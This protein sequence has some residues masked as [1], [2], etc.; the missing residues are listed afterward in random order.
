[1]SFK[2]TFE[3][4]SFLTHWI[5]ANKLLLPLMMLYVEI[6]LCLAGKALVTAS[7]RTLE[8]LVFN[9]RQHMIFEM[10]LCEERLPATILGASMHPVSLRLKTESSIWS[11][12]LT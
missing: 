1:M 8:R 10:A 11:V 7:E 12:L 5:R 6:K 2:I 3:S 9:M 4:E